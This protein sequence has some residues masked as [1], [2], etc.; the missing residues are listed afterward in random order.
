MVRSLVN[1]ESE[2]IWEQNGRGFKVI[3]QLLTGG[4]EKT[5]RP[6]ITVGV[7]T[8][9]RTTY[10]PEKVQKS[11][12]CTTLNVFILFFLF[13]FFCDVQARL[14]VRSLPSVDVQRQ[15]SV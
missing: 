12:R 3:L 8:G 1:D 9:I 5:Q 10:L 15:L 4:T 14:F 13:V 2:R 11:S 7:Q 6:V